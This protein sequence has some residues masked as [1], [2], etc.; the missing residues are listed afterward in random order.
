L[1]AVI[2]NAKYNNKAMDNHFLEKLMLTQP[3]NFKG[4]IDN[5]DSL[6]VQVIYTKIERDKNN[7]PSFTNYTFNVDDDTYFY[8]ASTVKLPISLLALEKLNELNIKGLDKNATMLTDSAS[9]GQTDVHSHLLAKDGKPSIAHY[10]KQILLVSDKD[11]YNRLYEFLG[12]EYIQKK[13][14]EKGYGAA[15]R[16]RLQISLTK[17]QHAATTPFDF[18]T[19]RAT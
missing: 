9:N 18:M 10:I 11:A 5:K 3:E 7:R 2:A 4:I 6:R 13:L 14:V 12:Q 16:H 17:E 19:K 8:P 15:I 1:L